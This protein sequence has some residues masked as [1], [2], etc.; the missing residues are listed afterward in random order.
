MCIR[1][2]CLQHA[3]FERHF[4]ATDRFLDSLLATFEHTW[5]T[6]DIDIVLLQGGE[7]DWQALAAAIKH[8]SSKRPSQTKGETRARKH[9]QQRRANALM[10][11]TS[12]SSWTSSNANGI[13]L[14]DYNATGPGNKDQ[15]CQLGGNSPDH[16]RV[17]IRMSQCECGTSGSGKVRTTTPSGTFG[18]ARL[19]RL[20]HQ[21]EPMHLQGLRLRLHLLN[22][23]ESFLHDSAGNALSAQSCRPSNSRTRC[24]T[25]ACSIELIRHGLILALIPD[26]DGCA[27]CGPKPATIS[28]SIATAAVK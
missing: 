18:F 17:R 4:E 15:L 21:R 3:G 13:K 5:Q 2:G 27:G 22:Y 19:G 26:N 11:R 6:T 10:V 12:R 23:P 25:H 7:V 9:R 16:R 28:S 1:R 24:R 14:I 20:W 8:K